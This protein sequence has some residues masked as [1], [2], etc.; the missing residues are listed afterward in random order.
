VAP[1]AVG[2]HQRADVDRAGA[3]D[4][5]LAHREDGVLP[6]QAPE[7]VDG[8]RALRVQ[9]V[10]HEAV[11]GVDDLLAAQVEHHDRAVDGGAAPDLL[12]GPVGVGAVELDALGDV[13]A[14]EDL[15]D[16]LL[17]ARVDELHHELVVGDPEVPEAPQAGARVHQEAEQDPAAGIEDLVLAEAR[18]V[19]LVD[20]L[21]HLGGDAVL[22]EASGAAEVVV[23]HPRGRQGA[24]VDHVAGVLARDALGLRG[25]VVEGEVDPGDVGQ[26]GRDVPVG[27]LDL[28]VLHVLGVDEQDVVED[29]E[30]LE[31]GRAHQA[32][33]VAAGHEPVALGRVRVCR[34][35]GHAP[36]IGTSAPALSASSARSARLRSSPPA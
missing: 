33:E 10:D 19:R 29:P 34:H 1:A 5:R 7:D 24:R 11:G 3:V 14:R 21:H 23:D 15:L 32:V 22:A 17:G 27:D 2:E 31:Q 12:G 13:R 36:G 16:A 30:L 18:G 26:V 6:A 9:R 35:L 4:D 25:V 8:D 28:A 20:G